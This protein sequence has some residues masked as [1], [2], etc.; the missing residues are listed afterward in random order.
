M[1]PA[2]LLHTYVNDYFRIKVIKI[3]KYF[4]LKPGNQHHPF[5]PPLL[6]PSTTVKNCFPS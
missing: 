1:G 6:K 5:S 3:A 4:E 2:V